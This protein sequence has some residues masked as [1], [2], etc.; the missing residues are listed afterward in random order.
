MSFKEIQ[1]KRNTRLNQTNLVQGAQRTSLE[2]KA[3]SNLQAPSS[4]SLPAT[5]TQ[6]EKSNQTEEKKLSEISPETPSYAELDQSGIEIRT[7]ADK[8][9][10]LW[11]TKN[12]RPGELSSCYVAVRICIASWLFSRS[13]HY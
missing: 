10:G 12:I 2:Q 1:G 7:S 11:A 8:G 13:S 4:A 5:A 9:R 3:T 6:K